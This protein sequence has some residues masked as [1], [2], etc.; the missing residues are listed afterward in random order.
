MEMSLACP[1]IL[2]QLH[3][4][5]PQQLHPFIQKRV[6]HKPMGNVTVVSQLVWIQNHFPDLYF[7]VY[8]HAH[9]SVRLYL[10]TAVIWAKC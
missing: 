1:W 10:D 5:S 8:S 7:E 2:R 6:V 4:W 9:S 3:S